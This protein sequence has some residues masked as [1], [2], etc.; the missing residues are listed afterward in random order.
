M[1]AIL[2]ALEIIVVFVLAVFLVHKYGNWRKQHWATSAAVVA[3]WFLSFA[4]VFAL[5]SDISTV[6]LPCLFF[7]FCISEDVRGADGTIV[8]FRVDRHFT[9]DAR[10]K[11]RILAMWR[12]RLA[13]SR[14]RMYRPPLYRISG[15]LL[16]GRCRCCHGTR[17]SCYK[18][19][20]CNIHF[21][22]MG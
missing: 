4:V 2:F 8:L 13:I 11:T 21:R 9:K 7:F 6:R 1:A 14:G 15:R 3:T 18:A 12:D 22:V 16:T 19:S 10:A 17:H 20:C 5:P